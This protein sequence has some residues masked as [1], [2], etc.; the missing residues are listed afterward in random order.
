M[1]SAVPVPGVDVFAYGSIQ[2]L[3]RTEQ[4]PARIAHDI[5]TGQY[6]KNGTFIDLCEK[7]AVQLTD[8]R[9]PLVAL[10]ELRFEAYSVGVKYDEGIWLR[11]ARTPP[12]HERNPLLNIDISDSIELLEDP[13]RYLFLVR[14]PP[15][16]RAV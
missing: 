8:L 12:I 3:K 1:S 6:T 9:K 11:V 16:P 10:R 5:A 13:T 2:A 15:R 14:Y 4:V 7:G